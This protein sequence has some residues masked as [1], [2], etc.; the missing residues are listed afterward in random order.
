MSDVV[1]QALIAAVVTIALA[2]MTQ[3]NKAA[4][5]ATGKAAKRDALNVQLSA[6]AAAQEVRV[7]KDTL[8]DYH[9]VADQKL[10]ATEAKVDQTLQVV[11]IVHT[12]SNDNL[13]KALAAVAELT[14]EKAAA[15][16]KPEDA[17]AAAEAERKLAEHNARQAL[18]D[19]QNAGG[20]P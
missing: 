5:E 8:A 4:I 19:K 1:W 3:R 15:S 13:R 11:Q 9:A 7:V 6:Q 20:A 10:T 16:G 14:R 17:A 2:W 18:V 12:L